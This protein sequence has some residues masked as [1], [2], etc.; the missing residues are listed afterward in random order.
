VVK[1]SH[2]F[3]KPKITKKFWYLCTPPWGEGKVHKFQKFLIYA[4]YDQF[5][6]RNP[7]FRVNIQTFSK[8]KIF[9]EIFDRTRVFLVEESITLIAEA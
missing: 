6:E 3:D 4:E 1:L 2:D 7:C 9:D 5:F 8:R